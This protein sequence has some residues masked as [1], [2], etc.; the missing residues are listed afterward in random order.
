[1][2]CAR[3]ARYR[4]G[5]SEGFVLRDAAGPFAWGEA[6]SVLFGFRVTIVQRSGRAARGLAMSRCG[7]RVQGRTRRAGP[8]TDGRSTQTLKRHHRRLGEVQRQQRND[9]GATRHFS[10]VV[11]MRASQPDATAQPE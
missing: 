6:W 10:S 11:R 1:V 5:A 9:D 7:A 3:L 8:R 2:E 4:A